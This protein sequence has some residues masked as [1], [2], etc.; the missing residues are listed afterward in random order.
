M[1]CL[2]QIR[3]RVLNDM[4]NKTAEEIVELLLSV[5]FLHKALGSE[6]NDDHLRILYNFAFIHLKY[7][8][9]KIPQSS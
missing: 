8:N 1:A 2:S 9:A 4:T 6:V 7:L 5:K 3:L